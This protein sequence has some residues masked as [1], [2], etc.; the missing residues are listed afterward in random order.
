MQASASHL[1]GARAAATPAQLPGYPRRR[2][3]N[4][5]EAPSKAATGRSTDTAHVTQGGPHGLR[6][7]PSLNLSSPSLNRLKGEAR[8]SP[9]PPPSKGQS[10]ARFSTRGRG[11]C[12]PMGERGGGKR[13]RAK[14]WPDAGTPHAVSRGARAKAETGWWFHSPRSRPAQA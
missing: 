7:L 8:R 2:P 1:P 9:A 5:E 14:G 11:L 12:W 10:T 3:A 6:H 4:A 13:P